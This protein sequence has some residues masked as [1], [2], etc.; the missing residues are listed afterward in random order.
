[1]LRKRSKV[2]ALI[3]QA[4]FVTG[5]AT[6]FLIY[7]GKWPRPSRQTSQVTS[8]SSTAITMSAII[9]NLA[10]CY[11]VRQIDADLRFDVRLPPPVSSTDSFFVKATVTATNIRVHDI[12]G[13]SK[14]NIDTP[15][16]GALVKEFLDKA[17]VKFVL[18]LAGAE[19]RPEFQV[20]SPNGQ[21]IWSVKAQGEGTLN[22]VITIKPTDSPESRVE[23]QITYVA[24]P[25]PAAG[26]QVRIVDDLFTREKLIS[27]LVSFL[28]ALLTLPGIIN[29]LQDRRKR[30]MENKKEPSRIVLP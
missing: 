16:K 13:R 18:A 12:C 21:L 6:S 26:F 10:P 24:H 3:G 22:G 11:L 14:A 1:V 9:A 23:G 28:G 8:S 29:Y 15:D 25:D 19:V 4:L 30:L 5:L 2:L 20:M 7:L 27:Y 17:N